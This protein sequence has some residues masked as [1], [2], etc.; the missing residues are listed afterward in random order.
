MFEVAGCGL[1]PAD[2]KKKPVKFTAPLGSSC[3]KKILVFNSAFVASVAFVSLHDS[4]DTSG[5]FC[6]VFCFFCL[7]FSYLFHL[8]QIQK[9]T[10]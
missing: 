3:E 10:F 5:D 9:K 1:D 4:S 7:F 2:E 6:F 8:L